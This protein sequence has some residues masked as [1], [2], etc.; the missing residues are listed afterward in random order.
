[1]HI[2]FFFKSLFEHAWRRN[3]GAKPKVVR[4]TPWMGIREAKQ[5]RCLMGY[6]VL[7]FLGKPHWLF[8]LLVFRFTFSNSS[9]LTLAWVSICVYRLPRS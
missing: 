3:F 9:A 4:S 8:V 7:P 5:G 2:N 6:S 1:M